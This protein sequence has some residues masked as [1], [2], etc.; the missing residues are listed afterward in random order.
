MN[1]PFGSSVVR[2]NGQINEFGDVVQWDKRIGGAAKNV[3]IFRDGIEIILFFQSYYWCWE[4]GESNLEKNSQITTTRRRTPES[5]TWSREKRSGVK[6][7]EKCSIR[8]IYIE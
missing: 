8:W 7:K 5:L 6:I 3:K 2:I 1:L 4:N